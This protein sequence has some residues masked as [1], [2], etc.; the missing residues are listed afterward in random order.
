M[1]L[2]A[3]HYPKIIRF[4]HLVNALMILT[5]ILSGVSMY[6]A[7]PEKPFIK[8][9][10]AVQLHNIAGI[11]LSVNYLLFFFTNLFT[12]NG[13]HYRIV[14]KGFFT[15]IFKQMNYYLFGMFKGQKKPY[16]ITEK[17]KFNP[18]QHIT[19]VAAMYIGVPIMIITG[20]GMLFPESTLKRVFGTSGFL[21]TDLLHVIIGFFLTIFLI[22]HIYFCT[23]GHTP[24]SHFKSIVNGYA[25]L[26]ES[27]EDTKE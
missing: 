25:E 24:T 3:Y 21:L 23:I 26:D 13:M 15:R 12:S 19:Y 4:W 16:P 22:I 17:R 20:W 11:I 10:V 7:D 6:Y 27:E 9:S 5:L 1:E 18:L 8:F 2:K 14:Y